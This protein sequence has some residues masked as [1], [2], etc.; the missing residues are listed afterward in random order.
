MKIK[1]SLYYSDHDAIDTNNTNINSILGQRR[2]SKTSNSSLSDDDSCSTVSDDTSKHYD[3]YD[4]R[5]HKTFQCNELTPIKLACKVPRWNQ[6][7]GSLVMDFEGNR[8][9]LA[10]SKNFLMY[11]RTN[12][13]DGK[14]QKDKWQ[15][16]IFHYQLSII[17]IYHFL[18]IL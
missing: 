13:K 17:L 9:K 18:N 5:Q 10:S 14:E 6:K 3:K 2:S 1:I 15:S 8:V 16:I 11:I 4:V 7:V 12:N